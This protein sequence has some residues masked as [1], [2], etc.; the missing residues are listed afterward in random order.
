MPS[1]LKFSVINVRNGDFAMHI[2]SAGRGFQLKSGAS[3]FLSLLCSLLT[4]APAPLFADQRGNTLQGNRFRHGGSGITF[5]IPADWELQGDEEAR[6]R[7]DASRQ[8]VEAVNGEKIPLPSNPVGELALKKAPNNSFNYNA[9]GVPPADQVNGVIDRI[10]DMS[11]QAYRKMAAGNG[12]VVEATP[13]TMKIA[14]IDFRMV[15]V[16]IH[17]ADDPTPVMRNYTYIAPHD[18]YTHVFTTVCTDDKTCSEIRAMIE[19]ATFSS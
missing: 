15:E 7:Y 9:R 18:G 13:G 2:H 11:V 6:K 8:A 4:M 19:A 10:F 12:M 1:T 16:V 3:L 17:K 5:E 14:D